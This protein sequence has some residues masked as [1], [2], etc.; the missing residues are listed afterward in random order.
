MAKSTFIGLIPN[1]IFCFVSLIGTPP[2]NNLILILTRRDN[3]LKNIP[4]HS[5]SGY[6][7]GAPGSEESSRGIDY[8]FECV[9]RKGSERTM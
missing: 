8:I 2:K 7:W 1:I 3:G 4:R 6:G 5:D 9:W